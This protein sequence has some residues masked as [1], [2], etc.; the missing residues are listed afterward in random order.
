M[1]KYLSQRQAI[2]I[3]V[4]FTIGTS[5]ISGVAKT[6]KDNAWISIIM[7]AIISLPV[8][9]IL[10]GLLKAYKNKNIYEISEIVLGKFLGK[11]VGS[12]LIF[13]GFYLAAILIRKVSEFM[14]ISGLS[15]TPIMLIILLMILVSIYMMKQ[16]ISVFGKWCQVYFMIVLLV[17]LIE[18]IFLGE[19]RN[20]ANLNPLFYEGVEPVIKGAI[21]VIAFPMVQCTHLLGFFNLL[22]EEGSYKK[23]F[24]YGWSISTIILLVLTID[25]IT[26]LGADLFADAYF[27]SYVTFRLMSIGRFLQKIESL[28]VLSY[29]IYGFVKFTSVLF[30]TLIGFKMVFN[31]QKVNSLIVPVCFL[32]SILAYLA[33]EDLIEV[34]YIFTDIYIPYSIVINGLLPILIYI[35]Y[36]VRSK[37]SHT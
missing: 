31:L 23:V 19:E 13:N 17:L 8:Y 28:M 18:I 16:G 36:L 7:G 4:M 1:G 24:M 32:S 30:S 14:K 29:L 11:L 12:I 2:S 37:P 33:Y 27:P 26:V 20:F 9:L 35:V 34:E 6:A 25:N 21:N 10:A 15:D 5:I 22:E 3:L